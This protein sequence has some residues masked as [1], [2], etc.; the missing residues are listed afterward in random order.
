LSLRLALKDIDGITKAGQ[1]LAEQAGQGVGSSL[2]MMVSGVA[3]GI[4]GTAAG[5]RIAGPRGGVI[6]GTVGTFAGASAPATIMNIG[7]L[8]SQLIQEG[9]PEDKA[10]DLSVKY[11]LLLTIPDVYSGGSIIKAFGKEAADKMVIK[12]LVKRIA[13]EFKKGA[14]R[15]ASTETI[16]QAAQEA[17]V[18]HAAGKDMLTPETAESVFSAAVAG[19]LSGGLMQGPAG[20]RGQQ[21]QNQPPTAPPTPPPAA[22]TQPPQ[23]PVEAVFQRAQQQSDSIQGAPLDTGT[24][25]E[26]IDSQIAQQ[27]NSLATAPVPPVVQDSIQTL[28]NLSKGQGPKSAP[29]AA[30]DP[31]PATVIP[32]PQLDQQAPQGVYKIPEIGAFPPSA[33]PVTGAMQQAPVEAQAAAPSVQTT[34]AAPPAAMPIQTNPPVWLYNTSPV[35]IITGFMS[36]F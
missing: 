36:C 31:S 26:I 23:T 10:N 17:V 29:L 19:G 14:V 20:I 21:P 27:E 12:P 22:P 33:A 11:G 1:W 5:T 16:Q 18:A 34:N 28:E 25:S 7:D 9:I 8:R 13:T 15:E 24:L 30:A 6:G 35:P 3:G 4:G 2:P 32:P